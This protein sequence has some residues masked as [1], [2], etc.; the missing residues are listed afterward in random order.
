M[1]S[2]IQ[3]KKSHIQIKFSLLCQTERNQKI[4]II[5]KDCLHFA[6]CFCLS[7]VL[8]IK[9]NV[10][11]QMYKTLCNICFWNSYKCILILNSYKQSNALFASLHQ[12]FA[13]IAN[14]KLREAFRKNKRL[15]L[16]SHKAKMLEKSC[17][18]TL[19]IRISNGWNTWGHLMGVGGWLV[20]NA[21]FKIAAKQCLRL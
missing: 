2:F 8:R 9:A 10:K 15:T 19:W 20:Q 14:R 4:A 1:K 21:S 6:S 17:F 16:R 18:L 3:N 11:E 7:Y 5:P 13:L 12:K